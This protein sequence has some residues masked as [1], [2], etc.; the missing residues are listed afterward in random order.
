[1]QVSAQTKDNWTARLEM[2]GFALPAIRGAVAEIEK[3]RTTIAHPL[4]YLRKMLAG[5]TEQASKGTGRFLATPQTDPTYWQRARQ[6]GSL[7]QPPPECTTCG[8]MHD[9]AAAHAELCWCGGPHP[10][11]QNHPR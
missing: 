11:T 6:I 8:W 7:V 1:M 9:T 10:V 3:S 2:E 4:G 5:Q